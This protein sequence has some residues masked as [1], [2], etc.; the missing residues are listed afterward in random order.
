MS[1]DFRSEMQAPRSSW[2]LYFAAINA[3]VITF[4]ALSTV[5]TEILFA[6]APGT[7]LSVVALPVQLFL[8]ALILL[9]P[10]AIAEKLLRNKR[11]IVIPAAI[12]YTLPVFIVFIDA[13]ILDLFRVNVNG[14]VLNISNG[15]EAVK[16]LS[17]PLST[18]TIVYEGF[19]GLC[20]AE[21]VLAET[22]FSRFD[23]GNQKR[24]A[25]SGK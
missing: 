18:W 19:A 3:L 10:L 15:K 4:I 14:M 5:P 25:I 16:I 6:F 20:V 12:L 1:H 17:I 13:T 23:G 11:D 7:P 22:L 8:F 24:L 2:L 9:I 21:W